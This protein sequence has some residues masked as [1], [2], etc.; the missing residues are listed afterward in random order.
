MAQAHLLML[1][2]AGGGDAR[3][4]REPERIVVLSG[5][6][7]A[8]L[9]RHRCVALMHRPPTIPTTLSPPPAVA[10]K[11]VPEDARPQYC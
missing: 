10:H 7:G 8:V 11:A 4:G 1:Q 2:P 9:L 5:A 6:S 3:D